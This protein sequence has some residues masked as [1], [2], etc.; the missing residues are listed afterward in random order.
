ME[1]SKLMDYAMGKYGIFNLPEGCL[2]QDGEEVI[3]GSLVMIS[4]NILEQIFMMVTAE[5]ID[6]TSKLYSAGMADYNAK[7]GEWLD[8]QQ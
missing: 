1:D 8:S 6:I 2:K 3:F 4:L 5:I 7:V